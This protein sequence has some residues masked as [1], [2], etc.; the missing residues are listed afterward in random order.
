MTL[1]DFGVVASAALQSIESLLFEWFPNGVIE[2]AE[3]CIGS[4]SGEAGKSLRVRLH[5]ERAGFWSDFSMDG[6]A[7]RDLISLYEV[8]KGVSPGRACAELASQ[9]GV[10][11]TNDDGTKTV[12][13]LVSK[14]PP[15]RAPAQAGK[16][17]QAKSEKKPA[18]AWEP[19]VP[20][21]DDA[22][23]YPAAH[24]IRGL[25]ERRW[26]YR[27]QERRLL[28]VVS[29]FVTSEGDKDIIPCVYARHP[30]TGRCDWRWMQWRVPR[31]LYLPGPIVPGLPVLVVEGEKCADAAYALFH[32]TWNVVSWPGGGKAVEKAGWSSLAGYD[33]LLWA[34]ADA[35]PYKGNHPQAG[36]IKPEWEQPGMKAMQKIAGILRQLRCS[37]SL[38]D[39]PEPGI[40]PDGW[41][42]ADLIHED[43]VTAEDVDAWLS[44]RRPQADDVAAVVP[45]QAE[46]PASADEIPPWVD[47]PPDDAVP[48]TPASAKA[49]DWAALRELMIPNSSGG[50]KACRENVFLALKHDAKLQGIVARDSFA[51]LQMKKRSPP[52]QSD[53][54]EW[55]EGDDFHL[56]MYLARRYGLVMASVGEIEKAVAQ[57][58]RE[59]AFNPVADYMNA[60][61]DKWDGTPR[62]ETAFVTYWGV[63]DSEYVR[64]ISTMFLVGLAARSFY[65]G[66]KHD[67]APVFEGGQGRGKS[68]ALSVLAGDW[69][70]D[71][72]FRMGEK[73]GY[74]SIQGVLLYEIA[75]LEQFNRSEVTAV[76]AFMS[77]RNDRYR[78]P[79]GRRVKNVPRR[80]LFAATT[81]EN[82]YFKDP[83]GN[84]RF[85]PVNVGRID[86]DKLTADRDQLFG[87]AVHLMRAK[88]KWYPTQ[89]QQIRLINVHQEDREIPD[90]WIGRLYDYCEG[91]DGD[92]RILAANKLEKVTVRELLT[93]ALHIEIG[94]LGP[95]KTE[96]MRIS[97]CMRKLGWR[98]DRQAS[99][100]REYFYER[101]KEEV[102]GMQASTSGEADDDLPL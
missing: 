50:V 77:S 48:L 49:L 33:V 32:E 18:T 43:G 31:P 5:G 21:P 85:W 57:I 13:S 11:I 36:Q 68:T 66:V 79:Y 75:E 39:I 40:K 90:P 4:T 34:D 42:I 58:A 35:Q 62:V 16:G 2:G 19:I 81:N 23:P 51:E 100:A 64:L 92:G 94:K 52:W 91:I 46:A 67:C 95:A 26:E 9:L 17:V 87:E 60:C 72:P 56:G 102:V 37:V 38:V 65:P 82:Q 63:E 98:K 59:H 76:K 6:E 10:A 78:E 47:G 25:P 96:T 44:K 27:D 7:G 69:Y 86:I 30:E 1:D 20:I 101:I 99:G 15:N 84:R 80:T 12:P 8:A 29:R 54:G 61:A 70:A 71:T 14:N 74:L 22:P 45:Q 97:T 89:E 3:F 93:R 73:D 55:N 88:T 41:D 24:P 28:G 83:T 53:S